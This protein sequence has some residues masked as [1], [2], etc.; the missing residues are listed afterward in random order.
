MPVAIGAIQSWWA[1]FAL[2]VLG[3]L[4]RAA[5]QAVYA[6]VR[7]AVD[8][9][10][11]DDLPMGAGAWL[12]EQLALRWTDGV[13]ALQATEDHD[14]DAFFPGARTILLSRAAWSKRD[15]SFWAV[16]AHELGH[17]VVHQRA[18]LRALFSLG[19]LAA[20][21]GAQ[22][23]ALLILAN[24]LW[25]DRTIGTI[26]FD[27][28]GASVVGWS[29]VLV[30]EA[31]A[32]VLAVRWLSRDARVD[33]RGVL[34]GAARLAAGWLTYAGAFVGE[35]VLFAQRDFVIEKLAR[36]RAFTPGAP[37][38]GASWVAALALLVALLALSAS[39]FVRALRRPKATVIWDVEP[40]R[41]RL[42][43]GVYLRGALGLAVFGLVCELPYG[44][45]FALVCAGGLLA[46]HALVRL[47]AGLGA[48]VLRGI[49]F[50][51]L[52]VPLVLWLRVRGA[53]PEPAKAAAP[54]GVAPALED[55]G[56]AHGF[57]RMQVELFNDP[58]WHERAAELG[59]P[60]VHVAF[61]LSVLAFLLAR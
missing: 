24:V 60:L 57:D 33:R 14:F 10:L 1:L 34:G 30:D 15:A 13:T 2:V 51:L 52:L 31:L 17:A 39:A 20:A 25:A 5:V 36:G 6:R 42:A 54:A 21:G 58:P 46:G 12:G 29:L 16:A 44:T 38:H 26:A 61:A 35:L 37:L 8:A 23:G 11:P 4:L 59:F 45:A 22:A 43:R 18:A 41:K 49:A 48:L 50:V 56:D 55:V 47:L 27:L 28:V 7:E 32:S 3:W 40:A 9:R 53:R 19:R